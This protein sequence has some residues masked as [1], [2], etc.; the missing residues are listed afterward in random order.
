MMTEIEPW[1]IFKALGEDSRLKILRSLPP[2]GGPRVSV[3]MVASVT[4]TS[5]PIA[6]KHLKILESSGL[7]W[8]LRHGQFKCFWK[9]PKGISEAIKMLED[10][11]EEVPT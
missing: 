6:S 9:N 7:A 4:N 10:L 2:P 8:S 11:A 5:Q 1:E 3:S